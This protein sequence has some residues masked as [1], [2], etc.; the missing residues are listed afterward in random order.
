MPRFLLDYLQVQ[1]SFS[2]RLMARQR[3]KRPLEDDSSPPEPVQ[4]SP[5]FKRI[6]TGPRPRQQHHEVQTYPPSPPCPS[7][8]SHS[9]EGTTIDLPPVKEVE[10][11]H[12]AIASQPS[13]DQKTP[14][15]APPSPLSPPP[16]SEDSHS[17]NDHKTIAPALPGTAIPLTRRA[18]KKFVKMSSR[19]SKESSGSS[20]RSSRPTDATSVGSTKS[21]RVTAYSNSF[22]QILQDRGIYP[23]GD[24]SMLADWEE[25]QR[26]RSVRP[27]L[28]PSQCSDGEI[29]DVIEANANAATEPDIERDVVPAIIGRRDRLPH[30]G[31]VSWT[32]MTSMT[33]SLTVAPQPDLYYGTR[34]GDIPK[35]VR[36]SIGHLIIPSTV[37][38]APATP[39]FILENKGPAGSLEVVRRQAA[40]SAAAAARGAIA[41]ESL[42]VDDPVYHNKALAHA[43]TYTSSSGDLTQYALR[44]SRPEPGSSQPGY[45]LTHVKTH[46]ITETKEQFRKGVSAFRH[47]RDRSH[48]K[49]QERLAKASERLR[50]LNEQASHHDTTSDPTQ[51]GIWV[52][53]PPTEAQ[54]ED[55]NDGSLTSG[56][57]AST[58]P[59]HVPAVD[60]DMTTHEY[61]A[62][63]D[64]Q[65]QEDC[66]ASFSE[67]IGFSSLTATTSMTSVSTHVT[68]SPHDGAPNNS[69]LSRPKRNKRP[70][71]RYAETAS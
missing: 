39:H 50:R 40:H 56:Y 36:D 19:R 51:S 27:S 43:W 23:N 35:P 59:P 16:R 48:A 71:M 37:P 63:L 3:Q 32:N 52:A 5:P 58:L 45:H 17:A 44:V 65:L 64:Q 68:A 14:R 1:S 30:S 25:L 49:N 26:E 6:K 47:C 28:A 34:V 61:Y 33:E 57:P 4:N 24:L 54:Q 53:A 67:G 38:N 9:V 18:L 22:P 62:L 11:S 2:W 41:L 60:R 69:S 55:V 31:N 15:A 7:Q 46:H 42:G 8:D 21:D 13:P 66:A 12:I 10:L 20:S 70:P 29:E